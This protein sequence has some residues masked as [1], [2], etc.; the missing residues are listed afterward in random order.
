[1]A[2]HLVTF[3]TNVYILRSGLG[4][5]FAAG[6]LAKAHSAF[7][8]DHVCN[9]FCKFFGLEPFV[10]GTRSRLFLTQGGASIEEG[11]VI[12]D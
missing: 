5:I 12:S 8:T 9:E 1:M 6:N 10:C 3:H 11:E 7:T 2:A 4:H